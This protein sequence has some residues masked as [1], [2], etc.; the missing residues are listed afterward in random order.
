[1]GKT[2]PDGTP[3]WF[4]NL[5]YGVSAFCKSQRPH[6]VVSCTIGTLQILVWSLFKLPSDV[7]CERCQIPRIRFKATEHRD[8]GPPKATVHPWKVSAVP[9]SSHG[10]G[11]GSTHPLCQKVTVLNLGTIGGKGDT[12][13]GNWGYNQFT[14]CNEL[15]SSRND[16]GSLLVF[17]FP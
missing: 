16:F 1:M 17:S 11:D 4:A 8:T 6:G 15:L 3:C 10:Q 5:C 13:D 7:N 14:V 9:L 12:N 2:G